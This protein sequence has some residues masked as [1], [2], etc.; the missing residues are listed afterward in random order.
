MWN[1][2]Y[3]AD[4]YI[5]GIEANTFLAQNFNVIPKGKVLCLAEG[6]GR[7]AVFLA[8]QG[9]EVTAVDS[10]ETGMTKARK[11]ADENNV[12]VEFVHRDL[13]E[14]DLGEEKWDGI[15]SI[16]C[17]VPLGIR[18]GL[19]RK[20]VK[21]LKK[22]GVLLLEAYT[23]DQLKHGTGGPADSELTMT[24]ELLSKELEGLHFRR[25]IEQEREVI[26]GTHHTGTGAVVQAIAIK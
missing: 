8:R 10:S 20:V 14:F 26:E 19:H 15:V 25:L 21:S 12:F 5:Y 17:H 3:S 1:E 4:H 18:I 23:P 16:F 2:R 22:E 24:A 11:L 9:Y 13:A 7:N 6:E